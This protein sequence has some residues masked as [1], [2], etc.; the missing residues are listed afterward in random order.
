[1]TTKRTD[2]EAILLRHLLGESSAAE[3]AE[4]E[5]RLAEEPA[6]A[7]ELAALDRSWRGLELPP[8]APAPIGFAT[9]VTAR[10]RRLPE[11]DTGSLRLRW[12]SAAALFVGIVLGSSISLGFAGSNEGSEE[13]EVEATLAE[14][15]LDAAEWAEADEADG[16]LDTYGETGEVDAGAEVAPR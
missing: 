4:L 14:S 2:S 9:R 3:R 10:A 8:A 11:G 16:A 15:Y 12:A 6:L 5:R 7:R 13:A 1:M